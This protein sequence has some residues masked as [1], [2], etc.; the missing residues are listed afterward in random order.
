MAGKPD[1]NTPDLFQAIWDMAEEKAEEKAQEKKDYLSLRLR[2]GSFT[3]KDGCLNSKKLASDLENKH[4]TGEKLIEG[5]L[6][7]NE[8]EAKKTKLRETPSL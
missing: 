5:V 6:K 3:P 1:I 2:D 4:M 8:N 7:Y